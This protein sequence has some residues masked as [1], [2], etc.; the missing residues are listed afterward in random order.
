MREGVGVQWAY[1]LMIFIRCTLH[2]HGGRR[3]SCAVSGLGLASSSDSIRDW[4][5][6]FIPQ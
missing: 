4:N 6:K 1:P 3:L 2:M 5:R